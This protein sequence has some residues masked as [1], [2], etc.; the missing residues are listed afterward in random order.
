MID[1]LIQFVLTLLLITYL[2]AIETLICQ[3]E[4]EFDR[5]YFV[6]FCTYY[7]TRFSKYRIELIEV[8]SPTNATKAAAPKMTN[9]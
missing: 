5:V 2:S 8:L 4:I 6:W 9:N 1:S 7:D 3:R